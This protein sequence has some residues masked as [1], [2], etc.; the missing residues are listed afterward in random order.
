[1]VMVERSG[2]ARQR[3]VADDIRTDALGH[4]LEQEANSGRIPLPD[5]AALPVT[6]T[7]EVPGGWPGPAARPGAEIAAPPATAGAP[8]LR[9]LPSGW[10]ILPIL[11]LSLPAWALIGWLAFG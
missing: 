1:M 4:W 7:G 8:D 3:P 6:L 9:R 10:W 5:G 2:T 11:A